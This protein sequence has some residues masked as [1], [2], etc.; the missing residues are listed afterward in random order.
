MGLLSKG[1]EV[2]CGH[3]C[4]EMGRGLNPWIVR[5]PVCGC[6]NRKH[7]PKAKPPADLLWLFASAFFG[8][9]PQKE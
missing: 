8:N 2:K 5:C 6:L 7:D 1:P 9:G 4:H 3:F